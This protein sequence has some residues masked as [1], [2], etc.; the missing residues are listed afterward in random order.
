MENKKCNKCGIEKFLS[1]FYNDKTKKDGKTTVCKKCKD[2]KNKENYQNNRDEFIE[3]K[4]EWYNK[5]IDKHKANSKKWRIENIELKRQQNKEWSNNNPDKV[6]ESQKKYYEKN[7]EVINKKNVALAK[8]KPEKT[9]EISKRHYLKNKESINKK[10]NIYDKKRR[11]HDLD[12]RLKRNISSCFGRVIKIKINSK[13]RTFFKY[14]EIEYIEYINYFKKNYKK[15]LEDYLTSPKKW[16]IDHI[17]PCSLYN[18]TDL[19]EI[20]K[21]WNPR[22]LRIISKKENSDK[23]DNLIIEL[24]I[25]HDIF[26]LLPKGININV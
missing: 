3:Y 26:D 10:R 14:T 17:I 18:F 15:E 25:K 9:R 8:R 16:A 1:E 4:K 22:N 21:C 5:N 13:D 6:K 19:E 11:S 2:L 23:K 20:K 7:K 12:Y 24:L